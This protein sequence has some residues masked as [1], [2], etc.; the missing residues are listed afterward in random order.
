MLFFLSRQRMVFLGSILGLGVVLGIAGTW[1]RGG[2]A[3][4]MAQ[5]LQVLTTSP[6]DG[7]QD[8]PLYTEIRVR[9]DVPLKRA[10]FEVTP[11][12]GKSLQG[13]VK[14][15]GE[16]AV[17]IPG[18]H[19][20]PGTG[21]Q[22]RLWLQARSGGERETGFWFATRRVKGKWVAVK[23]GRV[24]TV[25]VYEDRMPVRL[26]LAS[27][28]KP[29]QETPRGTFTIQDRGQSFW[30]PR[31]REGAL[32]WVRF[33]KEYLFHSVPRDEAGNIKEEEHAKLGLPASHGCIRLSDPDARWLYENVPDGALV[34]IYH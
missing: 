22:V 18:E 29:G 8:V 28:G 10:R 27:G 4:V 24:H 32:W 33:H 31:F 19:F 3:R 25:T 6:E 17:F 26:M 30:S 7:A 5:T 14:V 9:A 15:E 1:V 23:L 11:L 12:T 21:Y 13:K 20:L 34:I 2:A 16:T